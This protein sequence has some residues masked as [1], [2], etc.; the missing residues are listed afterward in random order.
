MTLNPDQ[1]AEAMDI[2]NRS[3]EELIKGLDVKKVFRA[4][5]IRSWPL[6]ELPTESDKREFGL[7]RQS[8][9]RHDEPL[10]TMQTYLHGPTVRKYMKNPPSKDPHFPGEPYLPEVYTAPRGSK[11][12]EEGHHR[13]V[14]SRLRGDADTDVYEGYIE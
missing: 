6:E 4:V 9:I 3:G 7:E 1:F 10:N 2:V 8:S 12:I 13:I 11:W 5:G 14:A